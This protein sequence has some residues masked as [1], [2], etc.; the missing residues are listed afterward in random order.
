MARYALGQP[1][2]ISTTIRDV[3]GTLTNPGTLTLTVQVRNADGSS[4]VTGTYANPVED[5]TGMFHQDIPATDLAS[6]DHYQ[7]AWVST[8]P[9]AGVSVGEFDVFDPFE[10]RVLSLQDAKSMLNIPQATT[11]HDTEIDSWIATIETSL[12]RMTGGP[13]INRQVSERVEVTAG[14]TCLTVRQRPLVSVVSVVSVSNPTQ[15]LSTADMTDLDPNAGTIRRALGLP[16]F[17][18]YYMWLPIFTVTYVAGWGTT[19]P[20][21]FQSAAR[22]ILRHLWDVERGATPAPMMGGDETVAV[23]GFSYAIPQRAYELLD[24]SQNGIPFMQESYV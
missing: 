21:A 12:E 8:G 3:T 9:G 20:A 24:G 16:L 13:L 17:G 19:V 14:Y 7:Y 11:T 6:V 2:R 4:T 15:P 22:I 18:P 1:V 5:S 23:P 10:P